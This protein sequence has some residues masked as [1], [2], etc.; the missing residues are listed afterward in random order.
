MQK[1][2]DQGKMTHEKM[3]RAREQMES[4]GAG[5]FLL[6]GGGAAVVF[7]TLMFFVVPFVLWVTAKFALKFTGNY[8]KML[9]LYGITTLIGI[10]GSIITLLMM[11]G[12]D[13]M[14]AS[15][16][17][18]LLIMNSFDQSSVVHKLIAS[19]NVFTLWQAGIVGLGIAKVSN[20]SS[21]VGMGVAFG[22]WAVWTIIS[23][24]L[25]WGS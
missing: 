4:S 20:K 14:R 17:A 1:A 25:G 23:S 9:E 13:S 12:F 2:V 22:L 10:L 3:D 16:G 6:I 21:G 18:G 24:L 15:P 5:M 7:L 11:Y 19:L 8:N